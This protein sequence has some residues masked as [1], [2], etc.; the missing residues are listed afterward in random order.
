MPNK[1]KKVKAKNITLHE[2]LGL[3]IDKKTTKSSK[4]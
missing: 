1:A 2:V 3:L 4:L